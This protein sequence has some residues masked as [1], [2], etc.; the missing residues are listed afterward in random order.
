MRAHKRRT[1]SRSLNRSCL[2]KATCLI[3]SASAGGKQIPRTAPLILADTPIPHNYCSESGEPT[4]RLL[5]FLGRKIV[6]G[7]RDTPVQYDL[8]RA[9]HVRRRLTCSR[10]CTL[11]IR[12]RKNFGCILRGRSRRSC[13]RSERK[14][15]SRG[16]P[17]QMLLHSLSSWVNSWGFRAWIE[18]RCCVLHGSCGGRLRARRI[19]QPV[20]CHGSTALD[21][22]NYSS[23]LGRTHHSVVHEPTTA[24]MKHVALA[25]GSQAAFPSQVLSWQRNATS[26]VAVF[27]CSG[28]AAAAAAAARHALV[29]RRVRFHLLIVLPSDYVECFRSFRRTFMRALARARRLDNSDRHA[30]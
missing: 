30:Q 9:P 22:R 4:Q 5:V 6:A 13:S 21:L 12:T 23:S 25:S 29:S 8:S 20:A 2:G 28:G 1:I 19:A 3:L 17:S 15:G 24:E 7:E 16:Q 26:S 14:R 10:T 18:P 27:A 11:L